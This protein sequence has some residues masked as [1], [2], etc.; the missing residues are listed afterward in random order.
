ML[1]AEITCLT[2]MKRFDVS[3]PD[4]R[5]IIFFRTQLTEKTQMEKEVG[6][7]KFSVCK[8]RFYTFLTGRR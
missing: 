5:N 3:F 7:K 2:T 6:G 4:T 8:V 1:C